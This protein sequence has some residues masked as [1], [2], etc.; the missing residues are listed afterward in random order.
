MPARAAPTHFLCIPL[1]GRRLTRS[2]A[3]F[4]A[5]VTSLNSFAIPDDAVRP[6]G[7]LH[8]TL[9]VMSLPTQ[10]Q[11]D[12]A[13]ATLQGLNLR[14][15]VGD[16]RASLARQQQSTRRLLD[17]HSRPLIALRGLQAMQTPARTS[18]LYAPPVDVDGSGTLHGLCEAVRR[19]FIERGLMVDDGRPQLLHATIVNT[20]Y[21]KDERGRRRR[22]KLLIDARG[23]VA[24]Y[25]DYTWV[26][27]LYVRGFQICKMGA[28]K[29]G[30]GDEAYEQV[31]FVSM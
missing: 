2:L 11:L 5:D 15:I 26:D 8:L 19:V 25:D 21:S 30:G 28:Q 14:E 10:A 17:A 6:P 9:G 27:G 23:V 16:V 18:V 7:T 3:S 20:I 24:Q 29:I 22:E 13:V 12:R 31:A 4:R 1:G